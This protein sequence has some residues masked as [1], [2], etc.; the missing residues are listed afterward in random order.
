MWVLVTIM[1]V[2]TRM[3]MSPMAMAAQ[4]SPIPTDTPLLTILSIILMVSR[5]PSVPRVFMCNTHSYDIDKSFRRS[6]RMS[7][8]HRDKM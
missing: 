7:L 3:Y 4:S 2:V 1:S 5:S 8:S 6:V